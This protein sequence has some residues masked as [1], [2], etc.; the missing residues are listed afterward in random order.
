[1]SP[2]EAAWGILRVLATNVMVAMRTITVERGYDPREFTLVPFG[3][4][5]P[6]IAGMIAAELGIGRILIPRDPGTFSA[7][8]MLVTDVHQERSLTRITPVD[9]T[10]PAELDAI[11]AEMETAALEDLMREQFPRERLLTRRHAG[12]RYRGQSYEVA[13]PVP[14]L[15]GPQDMADL[16]TR[17]HDAHQ[18]RYG[19]MAQA[20]AVEIVNFQVTAVGLIAKPAL[21]TFARTD[22]PAKPHGARHAYFSTADAREVPVFRRSTLQPGM[23]IEGPAI[24]EEKTST[25]VL[26]PGQRADVDEYLNVE[27]E[28]L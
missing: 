11:F 5:G 3:G 28:L 20:E 19:H 6:T 18:R 4:M 22:A 1:M 21:K 14:R 12:M 25:T 15:R 13:V 8:G 17:F 16:I 24:L 10:T 27:I 9:G 23:R 2:T 7:H 26:Y